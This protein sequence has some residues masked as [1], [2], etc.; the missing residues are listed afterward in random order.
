LFAIGAPPHTQTVIARFGGVSFLADFPRM[1]TYAV[2]VV[3]FAGLVTAITLGTTLSPRFEAHHLSSE[4]RDNVKLTLGLMATLAALQLGLLVNSAHQSFAAERQQVNALAA[5]ITTL[6]RALT[7]YGT[8]ATGTRDELRALVETAVTQAWP[9]R[10]P[11]GNLNTDPRRGET[12][13]RS[14]QQLE[15]KDA[16]QADVKAKAAGIAFELVEGHAMLV[17]MAATGVSV[18]LVTLVVIWLVVILFGF[19][20]LAPR[21]AFVVAALVVAAAAITGAVV[22]LV[23]LYRPFEGLMQLSSDPLLNALGQP[24]K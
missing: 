7:V 21:N 12:V 22:V 23:G 10:G 8:E 20:L 11:R 6:D 2:A 14:I 5:K 18:P 15:P 1:P 3:V 17:A 24:T 19:S 13:L 16:A 9:T 4:S